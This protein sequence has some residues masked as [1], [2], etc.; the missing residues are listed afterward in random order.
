MTTAVELKE[1]H[2]TFGATVAVDH[3]TFSIPAGEICGF[4]GANGAG[5]TTTFRMLATLLSPSAGTATVCGHDIR[6][7]PQEVRRRIGFMPDRLPLWQ[8]L[9]V[10]DYLQFI[11]AAYGLPA[12][13]VRSTADELLHLVDLTEKKQ[14]LTSALS[15]GM[16]QR[17]SLARALIHDPQVL[18]LDEPASGLDARARIE[19]RDSIRT[20]AAHGKTVLISSHIL[21]ELAD[22]CTSIVI[23]EKG[24]LVTAGP[25][26]DLVRAVQPHPELRI[27]PKADAERCLQVLQGIDGIADARLDGDVIR[28]QWQGDPQ[29]VNS[30]LVTLIGAGLD[31]TEFQLSDGTLENAFLRLTKGEV[32]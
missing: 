18:I 29:Q 26:A 30:V 14:T 25:T 31:I 22:I 4:V 21:T 5:K 13:Q 28:A 10:D 16:Q 24:T 6:S 11:G 2:R 15:R 17:L 19:L 20:L 8:N 32:Q 27:A 7:A 12:A 3:L 1:L 9:T 23:V